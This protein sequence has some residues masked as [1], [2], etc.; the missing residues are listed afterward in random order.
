M[1]PPPT[2]SLFPSTALFRSRRPPPARRARGRGP[3][4]PAD[5]HQA[6]E[7]HVIRPK[8]S[9][10]RRLRNASLVC[11]TVVGVTAANAPVVA[12][13]AN[14][15]WTEYERHQAGYRAEHGFWETVELPEEYRLSAV[16][17]ALLRT[18]KVLL[19]A[20]SG[21]NAERFE[22]GT[23]S[24]VLWDPVTGET[25]EVPTPE[26]LFCAGP[27]HLPNRNLL[28]AGGTREDEKVDDQGD[29]GG[30]GVS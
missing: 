27:A 19:I 14:Y 25:T 4:R 5:A 1:R 11:V 2:S 3:H 21:N 20:G 29:R 13:A 9:P 8:P 24:S 18:G 30:G 22:A 15:A 17:A 28:I 7:L 6:G 12:D 26:D 16:H 10:M 23:F